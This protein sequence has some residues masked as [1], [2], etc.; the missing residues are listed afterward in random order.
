MAAGRRRRRRLFSH[1]PAGAAVDHAVGVER[2]EAA[3]EGLDLADFVVLLDVLLP[4]VLAVLGIE[5]G[6]VEFLDALRAEN[7][8]LEAV[9]LLNLLEEGQRLREKVEGVNDHDLG[10]AVLQVAHTVEQVGD[11]AV[12]RDHRVREDSVVEVL[13]RGLEREH[14][15]LLKVLKPHVLGLLDEGLLVEGHVHSGTVGRGEHG[16]AANAGVERESG[17]SN[18]REHGVFR[19]GRSGEKHK[20]CDAEISGAGGHNAKPPNITRTRATAIGYPIALRGAPRGGFL[21]RPGTA[22]LLLLTPW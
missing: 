16:V 15:L 6:L 4:E 12:T 10:A 13:A 8:G 19:R 18:E 20:M 9:L 21:E 5:G 2:L 11:D 14:R 7:L 3:L 1:L 22:C 17:A